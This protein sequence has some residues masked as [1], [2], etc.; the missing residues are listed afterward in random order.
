MIV[1]RE[2]TTGKGMKVASNPMSPLPNAK[3]SFRKIHVVH[4][5]VCKKSHDFWHTLSIAIICIMDSR[6]IIFLYL[7]FDSIFRQKEIVYFNL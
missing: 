2:G 3:F 4:A 7:Y 5:S 6:R 1:P